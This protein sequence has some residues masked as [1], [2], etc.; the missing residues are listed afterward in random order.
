MLT[1]A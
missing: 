1:H